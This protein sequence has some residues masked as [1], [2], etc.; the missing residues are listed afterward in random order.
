ARTGLGDHAGLLH[1][2]RQERL[3]EHVVDLVSARVTEVLALEVDP[4][5]AAMLGEPPR[6]V[7]GRR[8]PSVVGEEPGKPPLELRVTPGRPVGALEL[9]VRG[10]ERLG[11]GTSNEATDVTVRVQ[12]R[13]PRI[14]LA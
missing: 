12:E 13:A 2:P 1:A 4:R 11:E 10:H 6:E 5:A 3:A 9:V 8:P 7:Q 14:P